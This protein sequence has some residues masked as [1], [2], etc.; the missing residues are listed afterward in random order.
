[1][2][3]DENL[4]ALH[5]YLCADGYVSKNLPH[6]KHKYYIIGLRNQ[7]RTLLEDFQNKFYEIFKQRPK[8]IEHERCHMYSK[9]IYQQLISLGPFHSANWAFPELPKHLLKFWLRAFFDCEGW[10]IARAG[11]DR[12][13][14]A[15]SINHESLS[16]LKTD[17]EQKF[18]I[19][20]SIYL[21]KNRN[22]SGLHIY[23]KENLVKFQKEI[24]FLHP[25]KNKKLSEAI[26][27]FIDY[28]WTFPQDKKKRKSF[29]DNLI[30]ERAKA[31][32]PH[33]IRFSSIYLTN[34]NTLANELFRTYNIKAKKY[35]RKNGQGRMYFE[36]AIYSE[37][38]VKKLLNSR[39]LSKKQAS[40]LVFKQ[41]I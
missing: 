14:A 23:G 36:L 31:K 7:N 4:A 28:N 17:L 30:V 19:P 26:S 3:F 40:K 38:E 33:T 13:V 18:D 5:G 8:L 34:I 32:R 10:V 35:E 24:G 11:K 21:K 12:R 37:K 6:Q 25:E 29:L 22:I 1:M 27:S 16:K 9:E 15:E 20:S 39:L 41:N 2:K